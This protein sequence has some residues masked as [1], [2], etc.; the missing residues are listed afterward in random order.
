MP[1]VEVSSSQSDEPDAPTD[2]LS[3]RSLLIFFVASVVAIPAA[4]GVSIAVWI[5]ANGAVSDLTSLVVAIIAG[6]AMWCRVVIS[7]ARTLHQLVR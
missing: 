5:M 1:I 3:T 7:L 4:V 6:G 2:L